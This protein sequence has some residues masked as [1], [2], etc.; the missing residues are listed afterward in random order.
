MDQHPIPR[1]IT[2]FEF[3]LVGFLT[4]KQFIYLA[5]FIGLGIVVYAIFPIPIL[6]ILFAIAT[7]AVGAA[8]AFMPI[9]DRPLD[10]WV[11]NLFKRLVS[12]TQYQFTKRNAAPSFLKDAILSSSATQTA[13]HIDSQKKLTNYLG[14]TAPATDTKKQSINDLM[15]FPFSVLTGKKTEVKTAAE[16]SAPS[17]KGAT[18]PAPTGPKKPFFSGLIKNHKETPLYGILIYVKKDQSGDPVRILKTN[19]NGVFATFSPLPAGEYFFEI[20]DPQGVH[21]FDTMKFKVEQ[22]NPKP[23]EIVS[24][25]LM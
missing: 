25:E 21:F 18:P 16:G 22:Q 8:F 2:S 9:N 7:G 5:I 4:I 6:N 23:L 20:K 13:A 10:I 11:K 1:Q 17:Q 14:K 12:P 24:K 15:Q 3:K 19:I